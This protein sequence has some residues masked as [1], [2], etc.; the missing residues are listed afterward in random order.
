VSPHLHTHDLQI[1]VLPAA[2]LVANRRDAF[3]IV[4]TA[5]LLF[6]VPMAI[7]GINLATPILAATMAVLLAGAMGVRPAPPALLGRVAALLR[8][9]VRNNGVPAQTTAA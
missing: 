9:A 5:L 6:L 2:L 8:P 7:M 3:A 1:L 4:V